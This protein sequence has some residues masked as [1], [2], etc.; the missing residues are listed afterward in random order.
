MRS[1][2][3]GSVGLGFYATIVGVVLVIGL[4][5]FIALL[6]FARAVFAWGFLGAFLV[7]SVILLGVA[8]IYDRRHPRG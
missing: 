3:D 6:A 4:A 5:I 2:S 7:L 1:D 8:W